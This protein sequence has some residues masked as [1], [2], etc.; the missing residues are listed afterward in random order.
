MDNLNTAEIKKRLNKTIN[1]FKQKKVINLIIIFLFLFLLIG[2]SWIRLQNLP[3]LKDSTSGEYIP[4]ALDPFYFL[5]LAE[6][7]LEQGEL[8]EFDNMRYIPLKAGFT[9]EILPQT[10]VSIY[11]FFSVFS[12]KVTLQFIDVISPV[13]FFI[14][15]LIAFFFLIYVLTNSKATALIS[16]AFLAVIPLYLYRTMAGFSDHESGGMFAFFLTLFCYSLALKFLD[17][18]KNK[19]NNLVKITLLGSLVGFAS[20]FTLASWSGITTFVFLIIPLSFFLFWII[21]YQNIVE[22]NKGERINF[23][24]FYM[25]WS[26]FSILFTVLLGYNFSSAINTIFLNKNAVINGFVLLFLISD[27]FI[28]SFY[29]R[30]RI[31]PTNILKKYRVLF[32]FFI[33]VILSIIFSVFFDTGLSISGIISSLIRPFGTGRTGSTVAENAPP[34]LMTWVNQVGKIFLWFFYLGMAFVGIR[35]SKDISNKKNK[36]LFSLFWIIMISGVLFS[37]ISVS[38]LLN[39]ENFISKFIY[40]GSL[41]LFLSYITWLYFNDKIKIRNEMIL[42]ISWLFFMLIAGRGAIRF[43]FIIAPFICFSAG[44]FIVNIFNYAKKSKDDFMKMILW[45]IV[46]LVIIGA[47]LSFNTFTKSVTQQAKYT[48]PSANNQWQNAMNWVS[49]NTQQDSIF[50]HWWDYGYWVQYLGERPTVTDGGH[51]NGFWDHLIGRY[52]LTT[53]KPE[54][55]LSF[56]KAQN[57]SHLLIDPTDLGKY[58]AYSK[59]GSDETGEDRYSW[60]PIMLLDERQTQETNNQTIY[61]YP[62]GTTLDE[63]I[64]YKENEKEMFFPA[65]KA[66][67][68]GIILE[69]IKSGNSVSLKQPNGILFYNEKQTRIPLRYI[70][71]NGEILDFKSGLDVV[72]HIIPKVY[73]TNQGVQINNLGAAIYLSPKVSK[74]L[75]AQLYLLND[76][77]GKYKSVNLA[78]AESDPIIKNLNSQGLNLKEFIYFNGFRGPIKI[79]KVDYPSD[80]IAKEEFLRASGEY[81][82]FDNL[83]P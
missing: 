13:I 40:F 29:K 61:V 16:S 58:P 73:Q 44:F 68:G 23:I 34:Y 43:F 69:T 22:E 1:F 32:S 60:I 8:P 56:M 3:L 71:Y 51:F 31:I 14:L 4:L 10:V 70:Y 17:K 50:V 66:V 35:A 62:G 82:E 47:L 75:F 36:I 67:M 18:Q 77:F 45:V 80:I 78:H 2:S 9:N 27:F 52:V 33:V 24:I 76:V 20:A 30:I 7:I 21:K 57:V 19:K 83:F 5:R 81:A 11:K 6:T 41:I 38:H 39:G 64:I 46:I 26:F 49:E 53:P 42:I 65:Q 54:T 15:G 72:I 12:D 74:S 55:A 79:W 59:I 37:R 48:G 63:D 28:I 25:A